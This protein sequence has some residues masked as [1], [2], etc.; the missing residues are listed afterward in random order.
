MNAIVS[1]QRIPTLKTERL[2]LRAPRYSDG[3][4]YARC[5]GDKRVS[6]MCDTIPHPLPE[7]M[8]EKFIE[9]MSSSKPDADVWMVDF[10]E[11]D[12]PDTI[13][14]ICLI[15]R[16]DKQSEI[17]GVLTPEYWGSGIAQEVLDEMLASNPHN[18]ESYYCT[19]HQDNPA[20]VSIIEKF[21]FKR[22]GSAR[23]YSWAQDKVV[24][25]WVYTRKIN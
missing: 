15:A 24:P 2:T 19:V 18:V 1:E 22:D 12:M 14:N 20:I 11:S 3:E 4:A 10:T 25:I 9:N 6:D 16:T 7:D 23:A 13:G 21:G 8:W 17:G 5:V